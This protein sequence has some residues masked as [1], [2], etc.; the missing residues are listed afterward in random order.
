MG[1]RPRWTR[2]ILRTAGRAGD[3]RCWVS[4]VRRHLI[5]Y[6]PRK[7][8]F[9]IISIIYV[10]SESKQ[11]YLLTNLHR[12]S[13]QN[14]QDQD[15]KGSHG[16]TLPFRCQSYLRLHYTLKPSS[17]SIGNDVLRL[18]RCLAKRALFLQTNSPLDSRIT[19]GSMLCTGV[20]SSDRP[21]LGTLS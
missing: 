14:S 3:A 10:K 17:I 20:H 4:S 6:L 13:K 7:A 16:R 5:R 1:K 9:L 12:V 2:F 21:A 19:W 11:Y 15:P 18:C 8:Q